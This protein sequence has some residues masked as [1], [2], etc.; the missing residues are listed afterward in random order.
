MTGVWEAEGR[1]EVT[2]RWCLVLLRRFPPTPPR[3]SPEAQT[4]PSG[5]VTSSIGIG[6]SYRALCHT[7]QAPE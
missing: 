2:A 5:Y 7:E 1:P 6:A 4:V 3:I